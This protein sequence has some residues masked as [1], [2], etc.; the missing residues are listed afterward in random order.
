MPD[1][2]FPGQFVPIDLH[3]VDSRPVEVVRG[4]HAI[5]FKSIEAQLQPGYHDAKLVQGASLI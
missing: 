1:Q 3:A 4:Y 2:L 5:P